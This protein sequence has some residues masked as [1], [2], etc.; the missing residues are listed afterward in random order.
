MLLVGPQGPFQ[1][2]CAPVVATG[3]AQRL[4]ALQAGGMSGFAALAQ[5][6]S[7]QA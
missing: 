4:K 1:K 3:A 5:A 7:I 6:R 2:G